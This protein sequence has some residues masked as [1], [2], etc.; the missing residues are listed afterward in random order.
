MGLGSYEQ[1]VNPFPPTEN[2]GHCASSLGNAVRGSCDRRSDSHVRPLH[3][4]NV[5]DPYD[6]TQARRQ[7]SWPRQHG[8]QLPCLPTGTT[9]VEARR[10]M[11]GH[12]V[13][14]ARRPPLA[15]IEQMGRADGLD[16]LGA[17]AR[18]LWVPVHLGGGHVKILA[19]VSSAFLQT[20]RM[21]LGVTQPRAT[22]SQN[23]LIP[24]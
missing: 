2:G 17:R 7:L 22:T 5:R 19:S 3:L 21:G 11:V 13:E 10:G 8:S 24:S 23:D 16:A 6:D 9:A 18:D 1:D 15:R 14:V 4:A 12:D 20:G